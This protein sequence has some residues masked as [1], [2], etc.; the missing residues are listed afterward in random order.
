MPSKICD[1]FVPW[2]GSLWV[3]LL[4]SSNCLAQTVPGCGELTIQN[5]YGPYD[6]RNQRDKLPLVEGSHFTADIEAL[7]RGNRTKYPNG[8]ID[9]T[10][11]AIP[12]H[13]RALLAMVRLGEREKTDHPNQVTYTIECWFN[14]AVTFRPD[15]VIVRMLFAEYHYKSG[16]AKDANSQLVAATSI[17]KDNAFTHY[18]I[19]LHYFDFK[20]YDQALIQAHKAM[21]LGFPKTELRDQLRSINKWTEPPNS[22]TSTSS[23]STPVE[24]AK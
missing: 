23:E 9:Y 22:E 7:I 14:R 20:N 6:Y 2:L 15:D 5:Q 10:L 3:A 17:A 11:R 4:V 8:D 18:N 21:A 16:R 19:G 24:S 13:H 1:N 12:N